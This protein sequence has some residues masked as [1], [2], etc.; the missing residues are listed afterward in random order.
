MATV[1]GL[2]LS[3]TGFGVAV[4]ADRKVWTVTL[5][6]ELWPDVRGWAQPARRR[7]LV[8]QLNSIPGRHGDVLAVVEARIPPTRGWKSTMDRAELRGTVEDWLYG[9]GIP[10]ANVAPQTLKKY[11]TGRGDADKR[12]MLAAARNECGAA[13]PIDDDNQADAFWL[14]VMGVHHYGLAG[15]SI[16]ERVTRASLDRVDWPLWQPGEHEWTPGEQQE[17]GIRQ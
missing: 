5:R 2:D 11:A 3:L 13:I 17:K 12:A 10:I 8:S 9:Q 7:R 15:G 14:M 6:S 16:L 4:F 1:V